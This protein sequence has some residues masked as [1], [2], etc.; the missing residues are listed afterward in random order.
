MCTLSFRS[1]HDGYELF[2][3]RDERRSRAAARPPALET[4][5][6][7]R[8]LAPRDPEGGGTWLAANHSG[9]TLA[10]LNRYGVAARGA[11]F[12]S[13][14]SLVLGLAS[15]R[16]LGEVET[17]LG[18]QCLARHRPFDLAAFAPGEPPLRFGWDGRGLEV[19]RGVRAPLC[20][21]AVADAE[22]KRVRR[23]RFAELCGSDSHAGAALEAFHREHAAGFGPLSTCMH[24]PDANTVSLSR[25]RV[26][27]E[28]VTMAYAAGSPCRASF[29]AELE[30]ARA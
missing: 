21:S 15:A 27:R 29:G 7:V 11:D 4:L 5:S 10:L 14:G 3:S 2:F 24:R 18:G 6:G 20:S 16:S 30:L 8:F 26:T 13:R 25:V 22:A 23:A 28:R 12:A 9:V 1:D 19:E 17:R